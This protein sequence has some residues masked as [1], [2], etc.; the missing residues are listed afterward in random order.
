MILHAQLRPWQ[1]AAILALPTVTWLATQGCPAWVVMWALAV[2]VFIAAKILSL[3]AVNCAVVR[4]RR[5]AAY[6]VL[7]PGLDAVAFLGPQRR[8]G[9]AAHIGELW[10]ALLKMVG[11]LVAAAWAT[12]HAESAPPMLVGWIGM[13][14]I[15]FT[16]HFGLLHLIS[17]CWRRAGVNAPP[18]MRS[19]IVADSLGGFWGGRWNKAFADISRRFLFR[20][21]VRRLGTLGAGFVVFF[22]S[23]LVHELVVSVPAR[24]GWGGPTLYFVLQWLGIALEK[25][26]FGRRLG[27][28][29]GLSGWAWMALFTVGP[30][31]L[32]FHAPFVHAVI[33]P[34][35]QA[36]HT[37]LP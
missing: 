36:L 1:L 37:Q 21:T 24:G 33:V 28:G 10:F 32:L 26:P 3:S 6:L 17:W 22:V 29:R 31:T 18:I 2:S 16:L 20:P 15:I 34:F 4:F 5:L 14:G 11:G 27:L 12:A 8:T 30:L 19:P 23:G 7:W 13:V 25:S 9:T 35:F